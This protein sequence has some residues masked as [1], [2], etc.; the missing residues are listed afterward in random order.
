[1]NF[2][3]HAAVACWRSNAPG[4][5][6]GSMLPDFWGMTRTRPVE[7]A[8]DDLARGVAF[9]H[10]TD[11][12]FHDAPTFVE[13]SRGARVAL[14]ALGLARGSALAVAHIGVEIVLDGVLARDARARDAYARALASTELLDGVR[15]RS[16]AES[17]RVRELVSILA[18]RSASPDHGS[19]EVVAWRVERA[20]RAR[21]RLALGPGD[22]PRVTEWARAAK[23]EV[24][25][26]SEVLM[27]EIRAG[28]FGEN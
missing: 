27:G 6:L 24:A 11:R 17:R 10:E 23:L 22:G 2:F 28:L 19:A 7:L 15:W 3:G 13:L 4:F 1:V 16:D 21:P 18:T 20:L 25:R 8:D 9:H 26:K 5:V 12:V 14:S